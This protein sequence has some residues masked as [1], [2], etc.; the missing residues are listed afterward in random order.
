ME[1]KKRNETKILLLLLG[2]ALAVFV[3]ILSVIAF[4]LPN[5]VLNDLVQF[6]QHHFFLF[7]FLSVG[8]FLI[9][10]RLYLS[11]TEENGRIKKQ[12]NNMRNS[13][14]ANAKN[15][16][17]FAI[18]LAQSQV[19]DKKEIGRLRFSSEDILSTKEE[20]TKREKEL[21]KA[22]I[23]GN[24]HKHKVKIF[25]KDFYSLKQVETT[26]WSV[27]DKYVILKEG[28]VLPKKAIFQVVV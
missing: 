8:A 20:K 15:I 25:F 5:S 23:L 19:V 11:A 28:V 27:D 6:E 13:F 18:D 2:K 10:Y 12:L 9:F 17:T 3:L 4:A 14:Q 1:T 22:L 21:E 24:S 7:C 26:V 16:H